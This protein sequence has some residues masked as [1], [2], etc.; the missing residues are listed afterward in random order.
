MKNYFIGLLLIFC[1][2]INSQNLLPKDFPVLSAHYNVSGKHSDFVVVIDRSGSMKKLWPEVISSLSDFISALP[3]SDYIS[4]LGFADKCEPLLIPRL[5]TN[6]STKIIDEEL[7]NLSQPNG[8]YTDLFEAANKSLDELNRPNSNELKF[9]FFITDF[10][11]DPPKNTN[12]NSSNLFKLND[13]YKN[14]IVNT[15]KLLRV[16][17]LQLALGSTAGKDYNEFNSVFDNNVNRI[18]LDKN[19]IKDWFKRLKAEYEREKLKLVLE[20]NIKNGITISNIESNREYL[21]FPSQSFIVTLKSS[22]KIPIKINSIN[23]STTKYSDISKTDINKVIEPGS[24]L[25]ITIPFNSSL[26][27]LTNF[28]DAKYSF[29]INSVKVVSQ[30]EQEK[31]FGI[32]NLSTQRN[33]LFTSIQSI[34][35][36]KGISYLGLIIFA[37]ILFAIFYLI[38]ITWIKP[39]WIFN[40]KG[41]K[42]TISL[43]GITL[44]TNRES[45]LSQKKALEINN[46]ILLE[47]NSQ[48][49]PFKFVIVPQKPALFIFKPKRGTYLACDSSNQFYLNRNRRG[50][51]EKI[52]LSKNVSRNDQPVN[53]VSGISVSCDYFQNSMNNKLEIRFFSK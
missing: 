46:S 30:F 36:P 1:P 47:A 4:I 52:L 11:N 19:S 49:I 6:E 35:V 38:W 44:K 29:G 5:I 9:L 32:L 20:Q 17:A 25:K 12:W 21:F 13:K 15:N 3:D 26:N 2:F 22:L 39:E 43:N 23:I 34:Y 31:E 53:L 41:F 50:K 33:Y 24:N 8:G 16:Y 51:L 42:I 37:V 14:V 27:S 40:R 45:Y 18:L 48:V 28:I 7:L 10:D